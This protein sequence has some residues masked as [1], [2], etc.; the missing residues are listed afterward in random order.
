MSQTARVL[1][2]SQPIQEKR[3]TRKKHYPSAREQLRSTGSTIDDLILTEVVLLSTI[4]HITCLEPEALGS[5][6]VNFMHMDE[7]SSAIHQ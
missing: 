3:N 7:T 2:K 1:N 6:H 5:G 4:Q